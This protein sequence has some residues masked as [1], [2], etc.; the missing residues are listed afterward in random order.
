MGHSFV[1][2][3]LHYSLNKESKDRNPRDCRGSRDGVVVI[4]PFPVVCFE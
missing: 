1:C 3:R 2:L 4:I